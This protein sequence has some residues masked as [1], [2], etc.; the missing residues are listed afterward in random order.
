MNDSNITSKFQSGP[1]QAHAVTSF[2]YMIGGTPAAIS[3]LGY[4]LEF[5][6]VFLVNLRHI[7]MPNNISLGSDR[8][9][10]CRELSGICERHLT[11]VFF[12]LLPI[13]VRVD[14]IA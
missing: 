8:S 14:D 9:T 7:G 10:K 11:G 3:T 2:C 12:A 13:F 1:E 5:K 4:L 6:R